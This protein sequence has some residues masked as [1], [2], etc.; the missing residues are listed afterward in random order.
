MPAPTKH[1]RAAEHA[2]VEWKATTTTL[3]EEAREAAP[4]VKRD[5]TVGMYDFCLPEEFADLN[6]LSD[7]RD[8]ALALFREERIEWHAATKRGPSNHLLDS[9]V[10]CVNALTPGLDDPAWITDAFGD[11]LPIAE[12]LD[13]EPGRSLTFEFIGANDYLGERP[14]LPRARGVLTTSADAAIRYRAPGGAIELALIEWKFTEDYRSKELSAP[15]GRPRP[16]R[17][18]E[19]WDNPEC[20]IRRDLVPYE[21]LFV[22]PFYQLLRQQLLAWCIERDPTSGIDVARVLHICP[23]DND[24]VHGALNRE[25]HRAAGDD[26][27]QIWSALCSQPDR[28][29]AIDSSRFSTGGLRTDEYHRRYTVPVKEHS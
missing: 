11:V 12:V 22:E 15:R 27:L 23:I 20:P 3:P 7:V 6:L 10:Q 1:R 19:L 8:R 26:T 14:S 13:I 24:G 5:R 18:R 4:Y 16:D 28:F 29:I 17:Y 2:A 9:Q 25:S 21:D